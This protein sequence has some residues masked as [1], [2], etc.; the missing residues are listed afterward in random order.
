MR[1]EQERRYTKSSNSDPEVDEVWCPDRQCDIEKHDEGPHPKV[2]TGA[3]K[4]REEDAEGNPGSSEATTCCDVS[5]TTERQITQD[6][7]SIDL[8]REYFKYWRTRQELFPE[9]YDGPSH[10][11]LD[12]L[13]HEQRKESDHEHQEQADDATLNPL[14]NRVQI[15]TP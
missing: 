5:C 4:S 11:S 9:T 2:D 6:R 10:T 7:V 15:V 12:E 3:S 1:V 14:E 8:C 13:L